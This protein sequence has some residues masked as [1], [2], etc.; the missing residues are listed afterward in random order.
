M[1]SSD[2]FL[3]IDLGTS[4]CR[5]IA[6][7]SAGTLIA[8]HAV[9]MPEPIRK[10]AGVEQDP[11]IWWIAVCAALEG[12]FQQINPAH[13]LSI[14]VDGTSGTV[15]LCDK[16]GKPIGP[17]LMYNDARAINDAERITRVAP[18]NTA[19]HGPSAGLA[20]LLWL[21]RARPTEFVAH[22]L[23]QADWV[24][25]KLTAHYGLSDT[26]NCMKLGYDPIKQVWPEWL[27]KSGVFTEWL[28]KVFEP[29]CYLCD[30][31]PDIASQFGLREDCQIIAGTTDSTAAFIATGAT[32]PGEAVTSLGSTLVMKVISE[33]PIFAPQFGVYSQP[34]GNYWLVGGG[35]N[36]GGA[37]LRHFFTNEQLHL[38]T[39]QLHP[40]H[41]S[42]LDYYPLLTPGERFPVCDPDLAPRMEPRPMDDAVFL[43]GLMEGMARIEQQGYRRLQKLGAP[44]P[45]SVRSAGGG[46]NNPAW[47][48]IRA[49][50]LGVPMVESRQQEAAYGAALL[51]REGLMGKL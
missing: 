8:Q 23:N 51:A 25:G 2:L 24:V 46:A 34:F 26:N 44:C 3:G 19:A 9:S 12:L 20:K 45:V 47:S 36:S 5:T 48:R 32:E 43:Q 7:D 40:E 15:L 37:V 14:A 49:D 21:Q 28:P 22:V 17:A 6:I 31:T 30:I 4:G 39:P 27:S 42:G 1:S 35:S 38:L 18:V 16:L 29:G 33:R 10:G 13:I 50:L 11:E 41:P